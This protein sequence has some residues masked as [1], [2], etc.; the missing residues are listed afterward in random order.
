MRIALLES[1]HRPS[2]SPLLAVGSATLHAALIA[3]VIHAGAEPLP[4]IDATRTTPDIIWVSK[5][6][7][8]AASGLQSATPV[9]GPALPVLHTVIPA[10]ELPSVIPP[11]DLSTPWDPGEWSGRG[12]E[13]HVGAPRAGL[14]PPG[15]TDP[16]VHS[17]LEVD[18]PVTVLVMPVPVYPQLLRDMGIT[19]RVVAEFV[20]D[21]AGRIEPGSWR[22]V[23]ATH[24][25][26][27]RA[28]REAV[29]SARFHPARVRGV[30]VRQ[31][32]HLPV[33][34]S[35]SGAGRRP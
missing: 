21:T 31:L 6:P 18:D 25:G 35:I 33:T 26:F 16:A 12:L 11:V 34:F 3:G 8:S 23:Q 24:E 4:G 32:V 9:Q 2:R 17:A 15:P 1:N 14:S 7:G 10:G 28:A 13:I 29:L 5:H 19:G 27:V 20:V 22:V 30:P